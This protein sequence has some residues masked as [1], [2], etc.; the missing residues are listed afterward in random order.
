MTETWT[1]SDNLRRVV[2][3]AYVALHTSI[4]DDPRRAI[5]A[6]DQMVANRDAIIA[7]LRAENAELRQQLA[8]LN[9]PPERG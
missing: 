5:C 8:Y 1:L 6:L 9:E 3:A 2:D 7:E 4:A